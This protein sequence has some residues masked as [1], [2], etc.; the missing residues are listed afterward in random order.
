MSFL[1]NTFHGDA[2]IY[3]SR[4]HKQPN[5]GDYEKSSVRSNDASDIVFFDDAN[6]ISTT[7]YIA[8]YSF[9]YS[10]FN[11]VVKVERTGS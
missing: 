6:N 1:L 3:V 4:K 8:V 7:Y 9:Q 10:T 11:L 2:D 5:K